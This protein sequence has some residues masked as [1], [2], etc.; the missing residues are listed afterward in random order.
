LPSQLPF[1]PK[2]PELFAP[3]YIGAK[4]TLCGALYAIMQFCTENKLTYTAI[5]ELLKLLVLLCPPD[6]SLP[7]SFYIFKKFF[8]QFEG[9][10]ILQQVDC[11]GEDSTSSD[12]AHLVTVEMYKPLQAVISS[13]PSV[14]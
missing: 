14:F 4:I 6:N 13:E 1:C 10:H 7:K 5:G 2:N 8:Q 11:S 9:S 12:V 3:L